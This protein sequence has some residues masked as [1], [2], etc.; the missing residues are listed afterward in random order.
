[1]V[2][3]LA[4]LCLSRP[5]GG[6]KATLKSKYHSPDRGALLQHADLPEEPHH[7]CR[8]WCVCMCVRAWMLNTS[9]CGCFCQAFIKFELQRDPHWALHTV[10]EKGKRKEIKL[11]HT[12]THKCIQW[13]FS[14]ADR[15]KKRLLFTLR[16]SK[17]CG[18]PRGKRGGDYCIYLLKNKSLMKAE[19]HCRLKQKIWC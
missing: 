14:H 17:H 9:G 18:L 16:L 1:M 5:C 10:R 2:A 11:S 8:C 15:S 12:C 3:A 4:A 19:M 6:W 13:I 7:C